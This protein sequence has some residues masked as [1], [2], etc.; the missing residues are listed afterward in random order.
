VLFNANIPKELIK[1]V[2]VNELMKIAA[3]LY[4]SKVSN[5]VTR[6]VSEE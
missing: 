5:R 3:N 1:Q 2:V 6:N 4:D